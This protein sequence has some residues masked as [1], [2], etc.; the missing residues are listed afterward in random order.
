MYAVQGEMAKRELGHEKKCLMPYV[1]NKGAD[2]LAH[3]R[4]LMI[5]A[6]VVCCLDNII[7]LDSTDEISILELASVTAQ[8]S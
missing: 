1:K 8:V 5:S 3:P 7:P 6:S 4:S 2:Q